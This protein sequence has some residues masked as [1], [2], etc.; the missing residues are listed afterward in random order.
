MRYR[1]LSLLCMRPT[2]RLLVGPTPRALGA[3]MCLA[4]TLLPLAR[5]AALTV[6][7]LPQASTASSVYLTSQRQPGLCLLSSGLEVRDASLCTIASDAESGPAH[8]F[9]TCVLSPSSLPTIFQARASLV[10]KT[11]A[12]AGDEGQSSLGL[13]WPL[14]L[15]SCARTAQAP[16]TLVAEAAATQARAVESGNLDLCSIRGPCSQLD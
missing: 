1:A 14:C 3:A 8:C 16:R 12:A 2:P 9:P 10:T 11:P 13:G 4:A 5:S 6:L 7:A 15:A